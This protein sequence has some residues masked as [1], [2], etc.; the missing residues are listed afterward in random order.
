VPAIVGAARRLN[1]VRSEIIALYNE[2]NALAGYEPGKRA[3][4]FP[5]D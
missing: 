4:Q 2:A 1:H 5:K 3:S